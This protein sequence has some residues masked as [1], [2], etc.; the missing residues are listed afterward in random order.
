MNKIAVTIAHLLAFL[1][2]S[3]LYVLSDYVLY[4]VV[5]HVI[6]Y[7]RQVV[8]KNLGLA[9]PDKSDEE[10]LRIEQG[11]Y[12][13][14]CDVLVETI[15]L[16]R[17]SR[18]E[19]CR[20]FQWDDI[21]T[22]HSP[23]HDTPSTLHDTPSTLHE[24]PSTLH[25]SPST[26]HESPSTLH[27]SPFTLCYLAHYGNWEWLTARLFPTPQAGSL[28]IYHPL[29]NTT[30][31]HWL[32]AIRSRFGTELVDMNHVSEQL[33]ALQATDSRH[34]RVLAISDQLPKEQYVRHFH[35]FMG[36]KTKV[37]TGTEQLI[38]HY[39]MQVCYCRVTS[40]RRGYY[41]CQNI[42]L[43]PAGDSEWPYTDAYTDLLQQQLY[44]RPELWLWS[45][46]RWRR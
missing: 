9:F 44:E 24:S 26:L 29:H 27:E 15:R 19:L 4:P 37:L 40:P 17:M 6:R 1:P 33:T 10:R 21:D 46:D 34:Y 2:L 20:R 5:R 16:Q 25:E 43:K 28:F 35:R 42:P 38:R 41:V 30:F 36:I 18:D 31:D 23:L 39:D 22:L 32:A 14:L 3:V 8:E 12:H 13:H 45:H 11:F 7:R